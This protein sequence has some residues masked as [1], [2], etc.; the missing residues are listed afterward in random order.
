ME[1]SLSALA[2]GDE[3]EQMILIQRVFEGDT[4]HGVKV[5]SAV[6]WLGRNTKGKSALPSP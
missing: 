4:R 2:F 1:D 3:K 6:C 5:Q